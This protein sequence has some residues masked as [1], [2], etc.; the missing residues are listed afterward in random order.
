[1]D[2]SPMRLRPTLVVLALAGSLLGACHKHSEAPPENQQT[3]TPAPPPP[4]PAPVPEPVTAAPKPVA[5]KVKA[6]HKP[7]ADEQMIDDADATGM[8]SH[9][10][11]DDD[12]SGTSGNSQP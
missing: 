3:E 12:A 8:T 10:T 11:T 1:M 9:T 4:A 7:T 6:A 5:P 2:K